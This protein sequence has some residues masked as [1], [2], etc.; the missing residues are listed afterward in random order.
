MSES[1][2]LLTNII[3][4]REDIRRY[5]Q[6]YLSPDIDFT[7]IKTNKKGLRV[8]FFA[9]TAFK[10]PAPSLE[11]SKGTFKVNAVHF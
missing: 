6:W 1:I 2:S 10:F 3:F 7:K 8:L 11:F 5:R 9:L 4:E